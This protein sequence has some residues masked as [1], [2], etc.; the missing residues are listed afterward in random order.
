MEECPG[1]PGRFQWIRWWRLPGSRVADIGQI[2]AG[3][4]GCVGRSADT[5]AWW[6][7]SIVCDCCRTQKKRMRERQDDATNQHSQSRG[8]RYSGLD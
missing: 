6:L 7:G 8:T 1:G 5:L 2:K 4:G 3:Q